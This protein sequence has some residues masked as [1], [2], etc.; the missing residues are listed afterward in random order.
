MAGSK[1]Y[2]TD[3]RCEAGNS[4]LDKLGRLL[5]K[6]GME[7]ID[8]K[9]HFVA[10]KI[11]F[12]EPGNLSFLRPNFAKVVAD[13]ITAA[14][15]LPFLTDCNTL[16]VGRR[17]H[18][19]EHLYAAQE[20]GWSPASAGCQMIIADGLKGTDDIEVPVEGGEY[21]KTARIGR[22]IIDADIFF[23]L[24][25]F[26]GHELTGFG[27]AVKNA[28]MGCGSRAGKMQM[29]NEGKPDVD[30]ALCRSCGKCMKNCAQSAISYD[31][32][33]KARIDHDKCVGCG[34]C[35]G[36]CNFDA[37]EN[38]SDSSGNIVSCKMAE[39]AKAA[40]NGR[41]NF[42]INIVN[43]VSP[44]CDCH[45]END[46]PIVPD[47]GMFA[48]FDPIALDMAS[49]K[50]VMDATALSHS[51]VEQYAGQKGD[52]FTHAHPTTDWRAQL[53]HGEKIGLGSM[54]YELVAVK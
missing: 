35:I 46:A 43:Q 12:G 40:I 32:N 29:H 7:S 38:T 14:G 39:Y 47:V 53:A 22:A 15:G 33:K 3:M 4:L 1:V 31:T 44:Y 23:T 18:A 20:N 6:A 26:K 21:C 25:H 30:A 51:V 9:G 19:I 50:A 17:K 10:I 52:H 8:F 36:A 49:A 11:H 2:F 45:A 27:G 28:G 16:Y 42:H 48:S 13:R 37:I 41:P 5:T 24:N 34:R 54:E